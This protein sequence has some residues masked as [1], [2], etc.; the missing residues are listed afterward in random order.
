M[1]FYPVGSILEPVQKLT[2]KVTAWGSILVP[3]IYFC[4]FFSQNREELL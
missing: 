3:T 1:L 2:R 4:F